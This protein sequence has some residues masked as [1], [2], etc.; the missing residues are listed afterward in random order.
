M[1]KCDIITGTLGKT[2]GVI[3]GYIIGST[4]LVDM[5]QSYSPGFIFDIH[6]GWNSM[7]IW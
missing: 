3:G 6:E 2:L 7:E 4:Q 5:I 1:D